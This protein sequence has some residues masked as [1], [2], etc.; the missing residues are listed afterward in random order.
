MSSHEAFE[1]RP[2]IHN[3]GAGHMS[4]KMRCC[5]VPMASTESDTEQDTVHSLSLSHFSISP[6]DWPRIPDVFNLNCE[7]VPVLR[8]PGL[9]LP[10]FSS[11]AVFM[12]LNIGT[13]AA[14]SSSV[15]H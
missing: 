15:F 12:N 3:I 1:L 13:I 10:S 4:V 2:S 5:N 6:R 7:L 11:S 14:N 8:F 9:R